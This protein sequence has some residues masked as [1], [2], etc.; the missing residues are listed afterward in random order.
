MSCIKVARLG[1]G[2]VADREEGSIVRRGCSGSI[3]TKKQVLVRSANGLT[4]RE[5]GLN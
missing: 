3:V 5:E 4:P 2:G 1:G